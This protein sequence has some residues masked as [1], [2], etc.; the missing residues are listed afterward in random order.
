MAL[1]I[2]QNTYANFYQPAVN[3]LKQNADEKDIIMAGS[4]FGFGLNFSD[5]LVD[6]GRFGFNT[7]KRPR[8]IVYDSAVESS[9]QSS[10]EFFPAFYDYFPRLLQEEYK[11]VYEN[12]AY[13]IYEKQ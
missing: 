8:F 4:D 2:R 10:K 3:Y 9:W 6:D 12:A 1:R 11:L 7:G 5:N 13:K